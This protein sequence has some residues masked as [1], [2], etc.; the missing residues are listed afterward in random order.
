MYLCH[1]YVSDIK[2]L[3]ITINKISFCSKLKQNLTCY[4][5]QPNGIMIVP[6]IIL[7]Y[8]NLILSVFECSWKKRQ[9]LTKNLRAYTCPCFYN[10]GYL[11][12]SHP[13]P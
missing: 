10:L 7:R 11:S 6:S 1:Y 13:N 3:N 9:N 5:L 8:I 4:M 12:T 2:L